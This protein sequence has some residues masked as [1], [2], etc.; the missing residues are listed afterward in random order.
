MAFSLPNHPVI[1]WP[2]FGGFCAAVVIIS[3]YLRVRARSA[4]NREVRAIRTAILGHLGVSGGGSE[5]ALAEVQQRVLALIPCSIRKLSEV[6][7]YR[8]ATGARV[9]MWLCFLPGEVLLVFPETGK[10]VARPLAEMHKL[11]MAESGSLTDHLL[12]MEI[13]DGSFAVEIDRLDDMVRVVNVLVH[14]GIVV[15]YEWLR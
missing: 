4:W 10:V 3:I 8:A 2:I 7:D 5:Q 15:R 13:E 12:V 6:G 14:Q 9:R 1:S 11:A